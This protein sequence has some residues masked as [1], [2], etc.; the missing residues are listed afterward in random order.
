MK[1]T[2]TKLSPPNSMVLIAD[3]RGEIDVPDAMPRSRIAATSS[4]IAIG[5]KAEMDGE[6]EITMGAALEI[7]PGDR[8]VFDGI[9]ATPSRA[10]AVWTVEWN[11][12]LDAPV[13]TLQTRVRVW[14]NHPREPDKLIVG[15]G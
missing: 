6:T 15:L 9:L 13:P 4:C 1:M 7:D 11:S 2:S 14:S 8:P 10:V 5:C 12:I 3:R